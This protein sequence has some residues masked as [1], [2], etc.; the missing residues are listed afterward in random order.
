MASLEITSKVVYA[1]NKLG[2]LVSDAKALGAL[3]ETLDEG[4]RAAIAAAPIGPP[5]DDYGRRPQLRGD[6]H[7]VM[8]SS[9]SGVIRISAVNALS[10][11]TG[12]VPHEIHAVNGPNLVFYWIKKGQWFKG[13]MVNHPGNP[14][15]P[16]MEVGFETMDAK[17]EGI[18][19]KWYG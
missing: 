4:L 6:I 15:Q 13:P 19:A 8:L 1:R 16:Y 5:R 14:P 2:Q 18:I 9:R 10:Q 3:N 12:A 11:E 7:K 17:A